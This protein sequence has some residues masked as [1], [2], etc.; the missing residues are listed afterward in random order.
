MLKE[1]KGQYCRH[2]KRSFLRQMEI[3]PWANAL[4]VSAPLLWMPLGRAM[5]PAKGSLL[6]QRVVG[7]SADL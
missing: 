1:S 3:K 6:W 5:D 2:Q 4:Q 7:F